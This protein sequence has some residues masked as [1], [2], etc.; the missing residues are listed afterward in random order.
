[1]KYPILKSGICAIDKITKKPIIS[2]I[3]LPINYNYKDKNY[4]LGEMIHNMINIL[5]FNLSYV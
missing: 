4:F 2:L 5:R 1:M 3:G